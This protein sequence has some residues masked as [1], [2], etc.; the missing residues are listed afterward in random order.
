MEKKTIT[1]YDIAKEANVS[2]ATVSRVLTG[3]APVK[4]ETRKRVQDT[5]KKYNFQPNALARSLTR[6]ES[7]KIGVILPDITHPFFST[8]FME[9]ERYALEK[10]YTLILC[11]SMN[12]Y[13]VESLHLKVLSENQVDAIIFMGGRVNCV[14]NS[15]KHSIEMKQINDKIPIVIINGNMSGVDCYKVV[16]D[17]AKGVNELVDYLVG[18]GHSKIGIIGGKADITSTIIKQKAFIEALKMHGI[19]I[20]YDWI[21]NEGFYI[22]S[23]V[24]AMNSILK[25]KERPTALLAIND[26]VAIGAI[27]VAKS[28]GIKVPEDISITGFDD[29]YISQI[30]SPELT[31]VNQ[32]Y[33]GIGE[34]VINT[35]IDI[36]SNRECKKIK[37]IETK[38]VIRDSCT[39]ADM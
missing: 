22:E 35:I 33:R 25:C 10:G 23:G 3:S 16:T 29:A 19:D 37:T 32:N 5:I 34:A 21:I 31:T 17:E 39:K 15:R 12:D 26:F 30:V 13:Q 38:I 36:I 18:L 14:K 6:R 27:K 11:N 7:K 8:V 2:P 28:K 4:D 9:T 20:N 1:I 24:N